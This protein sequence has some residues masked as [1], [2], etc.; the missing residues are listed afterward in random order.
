MKTITREELS[1]C[2]GRGG[3]PAYVAYRGLV[4]DVSGSFHWQEG[5][6]QAMHSAGVDLTDAIDAAPH[7]AEFLTDRFP[8][9]ARLADSG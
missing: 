3:A 7:E 1:R 9:V 4:Y 6:H 2:D 5:R 8:V